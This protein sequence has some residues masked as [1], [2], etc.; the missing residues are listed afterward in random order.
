MTCTLSPGSR[1]HTNLCL[2]LLV[3]VSQQPHQEGISEAILKEVVLVVSAL[4]IFWIQAKERGPVRRRACPLKPVWAGSVNSQA[5]SWPLGDGESAYSFL[6]SKSKWLE[7]K[8][9]YAP[10]EASQVPPKKRKGGAVQNSRPQDLVRATRQRQLASSVRDFC[11]TQVP[12]FWAG[13]VWPW[14]TPG[15]QT[16]RP[17]SICFAEECWLLATVVSAEVLQSVSLHSLVLSVDTYWT[18]IIFANGHRVV[19]K[20]V[21]VPALMESTF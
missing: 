16:Q 10:W 18:L 9:K 17:S 7:E 11:P 21:K 2:P 19:R 6:N 1:N 4:C 12:P 15:H 13:G 5:G 8:A 20:T 3:G 14:F